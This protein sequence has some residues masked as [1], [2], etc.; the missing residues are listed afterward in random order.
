MGAGAVL[1]WPFAAAMA[2]P[3]LLEET[4]FAALSDNQGRLE[5]FWRL[6]NGAKRTV[7]VL[8]LQM[9]IEY[10]F[11]KKPVIVP[12]N[13]VWYNVFSGRGGPDLYGTE[14]WDFYFRNLTLNFHIWFLLAFSSIP[15]MVMQANGEAKA[16]D[17]KKAI[18]IF[19][20]LLPFYIWSAIFTTQSH[21]EERF[22]YPAYPTL[23]LNAAIAF[24]IILAHVGSTDLKDLISRIPV[25]LRLFGILV[26][27]VSALALSAFR[28]I[29]TITGY[30]APLSIYNPLHEPNMTRPG[31][32]VCLGKEWYRF[33]SHY[34]LPE[35]MHAKFIRSEF[36][37]LLPGEFHERNATQDHGMFPGTWL[38]PAGMND[39]NKE[40]LGKYTELKHCTFL[41]D[42]HLQS[43]ETTGVEPNYIADM[44][45]WERVKCLPFLDTTASGGLGRL[46]WVP[47][48]DIVP[49]KYRRVYGEYC[50][51][52]HKKRQAAGAKI[53]AVPRIET[54]G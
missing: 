24:Y 46:G 29:G 43:T 11:Y 18:R 30:N 33:P 48:W 53:D 15:L 31:D 5:F 8:G 20:F 12:F 2:I 54:L 39:Q 22:M 44:E 32:T 19:F 16:V 6:V 28:T 51:L 52:K 37:G 13:I 42:S 34:L 38:E 1:G 9:A 7:I 21:K 50:L 41:V 17:T 4:L 40:D 10:Y 14:P 45:H 47:N 49:A 26:F 23:A 25:Q 27:V 3:F 35:A 36:A